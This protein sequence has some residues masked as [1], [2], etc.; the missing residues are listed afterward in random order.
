MS[1]TAFQL[2]QF[3]RDGY[4]IIPDLFADGEMHAAVAA[5]DPFNNI[6]A[7]DRVVLWFVN[8]AFAAPSASIISAVRTHA[9]M[10]FASALAPVTPARTYDVSGTNP[11]QT[12][13]RN[14]T[15]PFF[16]GDSPSS[17]GI[18]PNS[19]TIM[20]SRKKFGYFAMTSITFSASASVIPRATYSSTISRFSPS[21]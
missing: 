9:A 1:L 13:A 7:A 20:T 17:G 19:S 8:F 6:N 10:K 18:N 15:K 21:G 3:Q 16:A 14:V 4:I 2:A 5:M 12:N 11:K